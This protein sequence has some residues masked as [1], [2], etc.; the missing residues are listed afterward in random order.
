L[1][2]HGIHVIRQVLA[3]LA[4]SASISSSSVH[5]SCTWHHW[6]MC[7]FQSLFFVSVLLLTSVIQYSMKSLPAPRAPLPPHIYVH[8]HTQHTHQTRLQREYTYQPPRPYGALATNESNQEITE[9]MVSEAG[10]HL[11]MA[12]NTYYIVV[13][14]FCTIYMYCSWVNPPWVWV[15]VWVFNTRRKN[16]YPLEWVWVFAGYGCG[17][18]LS[19]PRVYPCRSLV[20]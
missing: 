11:Y 18:D 3:N 15:G 13:A 20:A 16:P 17:Y 2:R 12:C 14:I 7:T 19:Y 9:C 6:Q 8:A 1:D 4:V 10:R 5:T